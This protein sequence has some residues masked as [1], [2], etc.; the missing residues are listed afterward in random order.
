MTEGGE[1]AG[2]VDVGSWK[3]KAGLEGTAGLLANAG[4]RFGVCFCGEKFWNCD[5]LCCCRGISRGGILDL[6][7]ADGTATRDLGGVFWDSPPPPLFRA[8]KFAKPAPDEDEAC[9]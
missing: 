3:V 9:L 6:A 5:C 4:L 8:G 2:G 1:V 7:G